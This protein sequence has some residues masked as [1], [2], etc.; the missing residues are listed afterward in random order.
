MSTQL[1]QDAIGADQTSTIDAIG[2]AAAKIDEIATEMQ[3]AK[4][5]DTARWQNLNDERKAQTVVLEEL[6]TKHDADVRETET[7]AALEAVAEMKARLANTRDASKALTIGSGP[8]PED[9]TRQKGDFIK[10]VAGLNSRDPEEYAAAKAVLESV[11]HYE[12]NTKATL[13]T[14]DATGGWILPNAIVDD[15]V[16]PAVHTSPLLELM[17]VVRGVTTPTID[18][19]LRLTG[20]SAASVIAW[21]DTKTN[22]DLVYN[23]YTATMYTLASIYDVSNQFLQKSAGAAEAD[24]IQELNG[25]LERGVSNYLFQGTG[26]S[27]P[28]GLNAALVTSP[29]AAPVTTTSH[30]AAA[31]TIAG[32]VATAIAKAAGALEARN[33]RAEAVLMSATAYWTNLATGA[34][35]AGFYI[36]PSDGAPG[37]NGK[38]ILSVWGIPVY[39]ESEYL[40]GSDD[41]IVGEFSALKVYFG[42]GQRIDSSDVA[43]TRWDKNVT[44]FRGEMEMAFDARPAVYAGALQ[45]VADISA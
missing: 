26:S 6:Q 35:A 36:S 24:V 41:M 44:G 5:E 3:T 7:K 1:V 11:S 30:T 9:H 15:L 16:K 18:I 34:D 25:R 27:E 8:A 42:E 19:P 2:K 43:G 14:T 4:D 29:P 10:A 33:R 17:T 37:V 28:F 40:T 20:P 21:G 31:A 39:R 13:G 32:N 38:N 12:E 23:G 22:V 45:F